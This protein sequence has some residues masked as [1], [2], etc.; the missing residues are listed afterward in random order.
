[1]WRGNQDADGGLIVVMLIA[2]G[3]Q[4]AAFAVTIRPDPFG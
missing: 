2:T 4:F 3:N 1:L